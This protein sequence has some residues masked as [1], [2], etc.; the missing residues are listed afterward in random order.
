MMGMPLLSWQLNH[1]MQAFPWPGTGRWSQRAR[2]LD[3]QALNKDAVGLLKLFLYMSHM[4]RLCDAAPMQRF[5]MP[6]DLQ[7]RCSMVLASVVGLTCVVSCQ[8]Q[9]QVSSSVQVRAILRSWMAWRACVSTSTFNRL[10]LSGVAGLAR[11]F[12]R[13]TALRSHTTC[14]QQSL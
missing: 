1:V 10:P 12:G 2:P 4:M 8:V 13:R 6:S 11:V 7:G 9:P 14:S 3:I 5:W